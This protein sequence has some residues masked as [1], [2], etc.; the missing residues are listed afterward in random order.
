MKSLFKSIFI[1][2]RIK[3]LHVPVSELQ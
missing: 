3:V 1:D 2:T